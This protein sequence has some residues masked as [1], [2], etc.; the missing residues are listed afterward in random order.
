[1]MLKIEVVA[2]TPTASTFLTP[3]SVSSSFK[4]SSRRSSSAK[5]TE[6]TET[7]VMI[8]KLKAADPTMVAGPSSPGI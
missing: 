7:P 8:R 2:K 3:L 4:C 1:M 5:D 6:A